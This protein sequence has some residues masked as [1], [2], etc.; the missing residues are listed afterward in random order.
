MTRPPLAAHWGPAP[1]EPSMPVAA[2]AL[3]PEADEIWLRA[4]DIAAPAACVWPWLGQLRVAPYSYDWIDNLGRRSPRELTPG[5]AP[6][7]PGQRILIAFTVAAVDPGRE[8]TVLTPGSAL[9]PRMA[10]S[11]TLA[12]HGEGASRLAVR[13]AIDAP[14]ALPGPVGRAALAAL[15]VG[16]LVMMRRQLLNLRA[17]AERD[18]RR[19]A[20]GPRPG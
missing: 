16:D 6:L 5:L 10:M 4:V 2:D 3:V 15:R 9:L 17:L 13:I 18:A 8:L 7:A 12:P 19:A 14:R 1:L 20:T 11:Y